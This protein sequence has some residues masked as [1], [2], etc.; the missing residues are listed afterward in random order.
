MIIISDVH[1]RLFWKDMIPFF[2]SH[3]EEHVIFMGDYVDPYSFDNI[4]EQDVIPRFKEILEFARRYK[5]RVTLLIGNH[6]DYMDFTRDYGYRYCRNIAP[7][8]ERLYRDNRD[9]FSRAYISNDTLFTHAG[10]TFGWLTQYKNKC[11]QFDINSVKDWIDKCSIEQYYEIGRDR[12]GYAPHGSCC[13][14]DVQTLAF[15]EKPKFKQIF[16]HTQLSVDGMIIHQDNWWMVDSRCCFYYDG[17]K[18]IKLEDYD[19]KESVNI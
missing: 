7:E 3:P 5:N 16:S 12:G 15:A 8:L 17:T 10:V 1:S 6:C 13:W 19:N 4:S 2:E 9:L 18:V 11:E 14:C